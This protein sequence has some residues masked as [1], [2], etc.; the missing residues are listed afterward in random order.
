MVEAD[1][2]GLEPTS[3]Q[4]IVPSELEKK[5]IRQVEYYFGDINLCK[6]KFLQEQIKLDDGWIPMETMLK[7]NRLA[8]LSKD[9]AVITQALLKS[10]SSLMEVSE[11]GNKIRR[12]PNKPLPEM[13][14]ARRKELMSRTVYCKGFPQEDTKISQLLEFFPQHGDIDNVIMRSFNDKATKTWKFK[15]SVFVIFST[16]EGAKKFVELESVKYNDEELIRKMQSVYLEEKRKERLESRAK[17]QKPKDENNDKEEDDEKDEKE[18]DSHEFP[19]GSVIQLKGLGNSEVSRE[20]L[21]AAVEKLGVGVAFV[22]FAKG[23]DEAWLRLDSEGAAMEMASLIKEG[24][25]EVN[26]KVK[27][28]VRVIEG[29]EEETFLTK[30]KQDKKKLVQRSRNKARRG[31]GGFG[32]GKKRKGSPSRESFPKKA[33]KTD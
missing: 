4:P 21:R 1:P 22:D 31:K 7:F 28:E 26:D 24:V 3:T 15:G 13:N 14:E 10:S 11:D 18:K 6:D 29:E 12:S 5:I 20:D 19:R 23:Q 2:S 30:A 16:V 32:R 8:Q 27:A 25:L 33:Q 17:K 9:P